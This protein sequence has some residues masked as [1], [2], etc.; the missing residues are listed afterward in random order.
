MKFETNSIHYGNIV[1][2][3]MP[4]L[5]CTT[6]TQCVC[7]C[8]V[9]SPAVLVSDEAV[10]SRL[11]EIQLLLA[12]IAFL[13]HLAK[14][15]GVGMASP[16]YL[17]RFAYLGTRYRGIQRQSTRPHTEHFT[18]QG[19]I[20]AALSQLGCLGDPVLVLASRT[21]TGVHASDSAAHVD[22]RPANPNQCFQPQHLA[23][24]L[25]TVLTRHKHDI[26][27]RDVLQVPSWFHARH[28]AQW[29][30]Y[31]YRVAVVK[32]SALLD[33][34]PLRLGGIRAR[35]PLAELNRCHVVPP[36]N[37]DRVHEAMELLSG[38]HDF[39][40]F[41]GVSRTPEE[42]ERST[43]REVTEFRLRPAAPIDSDDPL[44]ENIDLWEFHIRSR[45]FL[46]RQVRRMVSMAL[47]A[48]LPDKLGDDP[49]SVV[50]CLLEKPSKN[51]WPGSITVVPACGLYLMRVQYD[52]AHL[53]TNAEMPEEVAEMYEAKKKAPLQE[54][55]DEEDVEQATAS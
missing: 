6:R 35:L 17:L 25:N 18:V 16:R 15:I 1:R 24:G 43:V 3:S 7:E 31:R 33:K 44:Y 28:L 29:R 12:I 10:L 13:D 32:A 22:L 45:S 53:D 8:F 46:Y 19:A 20:E 5:E 34:E 55:G 30:S 50:R 40:S 4:A 47:H 21:D 37:V 38:E 23:V 36:L 41:K 39:R 48:G 49:L 26:I 54:D 52:P 51:S 9:V 14:T 42:E 2:N 27:I 11:C